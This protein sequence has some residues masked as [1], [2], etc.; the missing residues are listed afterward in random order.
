MTNNHHFNNVVIASGPVIIKDNKVFEEEGSLS[1]G[2][3]ASETIVEASYYDGYKAHASIETHT[4]TCYFKDGELTMWAS[5]QT[6]FGTR[7]QLAKTFDMPL[8]QVHLKQ[9]YVGGGFGGKIYNH[10][11]VEAAEIAKLSGKP[12]QLAWNRKEE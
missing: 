3:E 6:P 9:I 12:G 11:A 2:R 7:E 4:A 5:T 8:E 1:A 10:Q